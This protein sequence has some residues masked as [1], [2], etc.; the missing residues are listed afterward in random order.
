M[1]ADKDG[2]TALMLAAA[3]G[4][5]DCVRILL[6]ASQAFAVDNEG[7]SAIDLAADAGHREVVR[8]LRRHAGAAPAAVA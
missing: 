8:W 5:M 1:Y 3:K 7:K 6:P 4:H 2:W